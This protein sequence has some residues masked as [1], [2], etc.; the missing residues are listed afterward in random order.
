VSPRNP[1]R[2][3][4][5]IAPA[6]HL[7]LREEAWR[8]RRLVPASSSWNDPTVFA[9][10]RNQLRAL[11]QDV[12]AW[13]VACHF[14]DAATLAPDLVGRN[15]FGDVYGYALCPQSDE[16]VEYVRTLAYEIV[17]QGECPGLIVEAAGPMGVDHG[18]LHDK[19]DLAE[20][21]ASQRQLLSLCW[22]DACRAS[23]AAAGVDVSA[24]VTRV[25]RGVDEGTSLQETLSDDVVGRLV[26]TRVAAGVRLRLGILESARR[27]RADV[28]VTFHG[29]ANPWATGSFPS[30]VGDSL[31]DVTT[32]VA[33]CWEPTSAEA[34]VRGLR[35]LTQGATRVGGY[36]RPDRLAAT[37]AGANVALW[38]A[39]GMQELHLYHLGLSSDANLERIEALIAVA[40]DAQLS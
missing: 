18:A 9:S 14:D 32:V 11:G 10:A 2:R 33:S 13:M 26:A 24:A 15:A 36:V 16:V 6:L 38:T 22:C 35:D 17:T 40:R 29:S 3:V 7:P 20:W 1:T 34:E 5:D 19:T 39:S 28:R 12:D 23:L 30:L 37:D 8:G 4:T 31:D 25:R 21:T 27:A